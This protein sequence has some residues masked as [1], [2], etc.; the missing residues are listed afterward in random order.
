VADALVDAIQSL[1]PSAEVRS[2]VEQAI[3]RMA[4]FTM[5]GHAND[6]QRTIERIDAAVQMAG[7][8]R[9]SDEGQAAI[10]DALWRI[11]AVRERLLLLASVAFGVRRSSHF[12]SRE[13]P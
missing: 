11:S 1:K 8:K 4:A 10:E 2:D 12:G 13:S 5:V 3:L 7:T 9:L 6:I